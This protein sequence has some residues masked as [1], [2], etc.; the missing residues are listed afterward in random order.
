MTEYFT[1]EYWM[2]KTTQLLDWFV[3]AG[4]KILLILLAYFI[5]KSVLISIVTRLMKRLQARYK[6]GGEL[7]QSKRMV[8]LFGIVRSVITVTITII[9]VFVLLDQVGINIAPLIAGAGI[10]GLAVAFG[11]QE[12]VR[13]VTT[14]FFM[15]LENY[16]RVG[17]VVTI[18]GTGGAVEK[19]ELR[20][21]A[22]R[23]FSQVV[24]IFQHGKINSLSNTT[25]GWSAAAFDI[26]VAYKEDPNRVM[27]IMKD[28]GDE[29]EADAGFKDLILDPLEIFGV[30]QFGDS[31]VVIKAR[32]KTKAGQRWTVAREYNKRLKYAFDK[33]GV[34]IPFP[35]RTIYWGDET[36][37]LKVA[38]D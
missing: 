15:L 8:T 31:A 35:H 3:T 1:S 37:P 5:A 7:E 23:D 20:T 22:L 9:F 12:L 32:Y 17:D 14:G 13:D 19:I 29:L 6:A 26:G 16:V 21:I 27:K 25:M 11:S 28:V 2:T 24:H 33:H 10:I 18:N 36:P 34:E 38:K 4:P 30:D